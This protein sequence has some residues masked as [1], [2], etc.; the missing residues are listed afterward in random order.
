M[1]ACG[2]CGVCGLDKIECVLFSQNTCR[3]GLPVLASIGK[4]AFMPHDCLRVMVDLGCFMNK[5][6]KIATEAHMS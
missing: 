3:P 5:E 2:V 6:K 4:L 1:C